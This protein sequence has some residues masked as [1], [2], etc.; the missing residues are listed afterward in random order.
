MYICEDIFILHI[1]IAVVSL[2]PSSRAL[3]IA[4]DTVPVQTEE[5]TH[6]VSTEEHFTQVLANKVPMEKSTLKIVT[7]EATTIPTSKALVMTSEMRQFMVQ[8][9]PV[10]IGETNASPLPYESTIN[11]I[12]ETRSGSILPA[13]TQVMDIMKELIL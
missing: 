9:A 7:Q 13:L 5:S 8:F 2:Y 4:G 6:S 10:F 12:M 11:N 1:Y 3:Q